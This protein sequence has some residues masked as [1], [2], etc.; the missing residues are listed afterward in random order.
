MNGGENITNSECTDT[1]DTFDVPAD[2]L[3]VS[4][5]D[6]PDNGK[7]GKKRGFFSRIRCLDSLTLK[8]I[9]MALMLCDHMWVTV[10]YEHEWLTVI[11]RIAFPIFAFQIVEGFFHT[12]SRGK[13]LLRMFIFALMSEIPFNFLVGGGPIYPFHQNVMF[14]FCISLLTMMVL[15]RAKHHAWWVFLIAVIV[16]VPL[17]YVLGFI[18]FV[19]YFGYGI[20]TVLVFYLFHGVK[21]GWIAE[22][23]A[24]IYI[25]WVMIGGL[26][27]NVTIFGR[28]VEIPEQ[29]FAVLALIPIMLYNGKPGSKNKVVQ[30][31]CYAFYP[32]H[33]IVLVTLSHLLF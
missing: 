10:A 21:F 15:E 28:E 31:A 20:L 26:V 18:T 30:Y 1:A 2:T 4:A 29:G 12:H 17:T 11:G 3:D 24:L 22:T 13:Y 6:A 25:N 9:A 23:A 19:D 27:F 33:M 14:T 5:P 7:N 32:V 8:I 16:A